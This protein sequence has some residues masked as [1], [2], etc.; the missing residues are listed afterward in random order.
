MLPVNLSTAALLKGIDRNQIVL[1]IRLDA[2]AAEEDQRG[3]VGRVPNGTA[4]ICSANQ[5][6]LM[7][8]EKPGLFVAELI[9]E[10]RSPRRWRMYSSA[11]AWMCC[12]VPIAN[13][14]P[15]TRPPWKRNSFLRA[16][17]ETHG[18]AGENRPRAARGQASGF[19]PRPRQR[20]ESMPDDNAARDESIRQLDAR[21]RANPNDVAAIYTRGQIYAKNRNFSMRRTGTFPAPSKTSMRWSGST[22]NAEALNNRC[23]AR[24]ITGHLSGALKLRAFDP[25][26]PMLTTAAVWST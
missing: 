15:G 23:W 10:M 8:E 16:C 9:K 17:R 2:V 5:G 22:R 6:T 26:T 4:F 11:R 21:I 14:L 7:E 13:K 18:G 24:A 12:A 20:P 19:A 1:P 3:R 25:A